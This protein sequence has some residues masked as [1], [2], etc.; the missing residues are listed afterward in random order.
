[1]KN[2]IYIAGALSEQK[3]TKQF[4]N[5]FEDLKRFYEDIGAICEKHGIESFI[6]HLRHD[7]IKNPDLTPEGVYRR[8]A[9]KLTQSD[10]LIAYVG[11]PSL[12][13][14]IELQLVK[15]A[16]IP[17]VLLY[18]KDKYISRMARGNPAVIK[19]IIF[20]DFDDALA[21]LHD[22]LRNWTGGIIGKLTRL[23]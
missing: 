4:F 3:Q 6:P 19:E 21:Q 2:K 12:G 10:L 23:D 17:T 8:N 18:E 7:P 14:G 15:Q 16:D 5:L 22:F 13:V 1:M 20:S 11:L 9:D